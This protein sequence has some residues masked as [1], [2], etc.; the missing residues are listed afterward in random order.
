MGRR[1]VSEN[2]LRWSTAYSQTSSDDGYHDNSSDDNLTEPCHAV[3]EDLIPGVPTQV[4]WWE[5][6]YS[7]VVRLLLQFYCCP[8][9]GLLCGEGSFRSLS[10]MI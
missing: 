7:A 2:Y 1:S 8:L 3:W 9:S 6:G 4:G 5:D 10:L